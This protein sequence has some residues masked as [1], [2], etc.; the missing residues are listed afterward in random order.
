MRRPNRSR[1]DPERLAALARLTGEDAGRT[2]ELLDAF[3]E[4]DRLVQGASTESLAAPFAWVR[5]QMAAQIERARPLVAAWA[6]AQDVVPRVPRCGGQQTIPRRRPRQCGATA[7]GRADC[8]LGDTNVPRWPASGL[9]IPG[10]P[11]HRRDRPTALRRASGRPWRVASLASF[12][13]RSPMRD[14]GRTSSAALRRLAA[15]TASRP[16]TWRA[17]R[18]HRLH[19]RVRGRPATRSW[20]RW[21]SPKLVS[22]SM[23]VRPTS[24]SRPRAGRDPQPWGRTQAVPRSTC[25]RSDA[26]PVY[27]ARESVSGACGCA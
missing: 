3:D 5:D 21:R 27:V 4:A 20:G 15:C 2:R 7:H 1:A 12:R 26:A 23:P 16:V 11:G 19:A 6:L 17:G 22:P 8:C 9:R 18:H 10:H 14:G 24:S 13:G 25:V